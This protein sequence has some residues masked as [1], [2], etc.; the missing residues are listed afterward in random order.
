MVNHY[1][2]KYI[3][4]P[5]EKNISSIRLIEKFNLN[6]KYKL[7]ETNFRTKQV[8]H[9][10]LALLM[11][12]SGSTGSPKF[13]KLS[14]S[15]LLDNANKIAQYLNIKSSDRPITTMQP[16]YSYGLSIINSHLIKGSSIITTEASLFEKKFWQLFKKNKAI[17]SYFKHCTFLFYILG[18]LPELFCLH[19]SLFIFSVFLWGIVRPKL[20]D[21]KGVII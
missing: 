1:R 16:S 6:N 13:V 17:I 10:E 18:R 3:L 9:A 2:P 7:F 5:K 12:T 8:V 11:T 20:L 21:K 19:L 15:N 4:I 14:Y